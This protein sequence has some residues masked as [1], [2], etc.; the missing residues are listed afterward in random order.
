MKKPISEYFIEAIMRI[1]AAISVVITIA[2]IFTL[3]KE[4]FPFFQQVNIFSF[5]TGTSWNPRPESG[6]FGVIPLLVGTFIIVIISSVFALPLGLGAAV[7]MS[8]YA[9]AKTRSFVKPVLELLAGIPSVVYGFFALK[10]ITP[11]IQSLFGSFGVE[12]ATLNALSAALAVGIM[13]LPTVASLSEDAIK[14]V[15]NSIREASYGL[16]TTKYET[17]KNI[18]IPA[19]FS[20]IVASFIL[21]ISRAIGET[22]IVAIAAGASPTLTFNPLESIQTMTGF[23]VNKVQGEVVVGTIEYQTIYAVAL[24]LF[25]LTLV[26]NYLSKIIAKKYQNKYE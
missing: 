26:F 21:A 3:L 23:I 24:L 14:A 15:P 6:S 20:G 4:S 13:I 9:S 2:I 11:A 1:F 22:M 12:V 17:I 19:G 16:G 10:F 25:V 18:I 8:E 7:F 5:L